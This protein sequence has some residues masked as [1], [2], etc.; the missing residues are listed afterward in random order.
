VPP[1]YTAHL[2]IILDAVVQKIHG[3]SPTI[4]TEAT[5]SGNFITYISAR[6]CN[7][8]YKSPPMI[9]KDEAEA[10]AIYRYR[11]YQTN[12]VGY[13]I[14]DLNYPT[15]A[16]LVC[17]INKYNEEVNELLLCATN[18]ATMIQLTAGP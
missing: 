6:N 7:E 12:I 11:R 13:N 5:E 18:A 9:R 1:N 17:E 10:D 15:L 4:T 3:T 16:K 8:C 14:V 2:K